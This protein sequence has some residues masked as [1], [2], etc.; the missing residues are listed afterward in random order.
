VHLTVFFMLILKEI[1]LK[2]ENKYQVKSV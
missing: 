2:K 1:E